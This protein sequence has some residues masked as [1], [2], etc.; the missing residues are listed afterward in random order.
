M[1]RIHRVGK[2]DQFLRALGEM[3]TFSWYSR[4]HETPN[5]QKNAGKKWAAF[6][7]AESLRCVSTT[8]HLRDQLY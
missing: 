8:V 3:A 5:K 1:R 4:T 2:H 7:T 6:T